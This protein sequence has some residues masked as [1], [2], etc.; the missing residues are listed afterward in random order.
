MLPAGDV[1]PVDTDGRPDRSFLER[2]AN[3]DAV[4]NKDRPE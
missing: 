2:K 3:R 1:V 4:L